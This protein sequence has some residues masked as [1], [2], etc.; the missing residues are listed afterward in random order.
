MNSTVE[1]VAFASTWVIALAYPVLLILLVLT[2]LL[3][4][5]DS[6]PARIVL[7]TFIANIVLTVLAPFIY[8]VFGIWIERI[9]FKEL[10]KAEREFSDMI[11]SDMKALPSNWNVTKT[12]F[13]CE[14]VVISNDYLKR[15]FWAFRSLFGGRSNSFTKMLE[16]ARREAT[17]R[18]MRRAREF[19]ANVV[20][21]VRL[22]TTVIQNGN[23]HNGKAGAG[24][25]VLAYGTAF[26][27][28]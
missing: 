20:W 23:A 21:N 8:S 24:V 17:L 11:V 26:H 4:G 1:K 10:D 9:H 15:F 2:G 25:E 18:M 19:G 12:Y 13:V 3:F 27:V 6:L 16:R 5:D 28:E 14:N 7:V 22:E